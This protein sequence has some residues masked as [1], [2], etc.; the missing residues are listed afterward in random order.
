M[1]LEELYYAYPATPTSVYGTISI[2]GAGKNDLGNA[3]NKGLIYL[4]YTYIM[5]F[6]LVTHCLLT[7]NNEIQTHQFDYPNLSQKHY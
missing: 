3:P 7:E 4:L 1:E 5:S 2:I 6:I